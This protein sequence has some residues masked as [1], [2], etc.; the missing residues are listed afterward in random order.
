MRR[1]YGD[2]NLGFLFCVL[3]IKLNSHAVCDKMRDNHL[4]S[5]VCT[6]LNSI[7][8]TQLKAESQRDLGHALDEC[9]KAVFLLGEGSYAYRL[10]IWL[11]LSNQTCCSL[12]SRLRHAPY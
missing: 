1:I 12:L 9:T 8:S 3:Q 11:T 2:R 4:S 7:S 10:L 6:D 5:T